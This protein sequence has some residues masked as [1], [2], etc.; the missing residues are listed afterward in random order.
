MELNEKGLELFELFSKSFTKTIIQS[1]QELLN[2]KHL[3]QSVRVEYPDKEKLSETLINEIEKIGEVPF[4]DAVDLFDELYSIATNAAW[5]IETHFGP[6]GDLVTSGVIDYTPKLLISPNTVKSYCRICENVEP[7]NFLHGYDVLNEFI[8]DDFQAQVFPLTYQCQGCKDVP[9][10]FLVRREGNKLTL[11]G[12]SPI[13]KVIVPKFLPKEQAMYVSNAI[14]A[15]NSG[16]ILSGIF[17]LRT[18]IEQYVRCSNPKTKDIESLFKEY[19][20]PLPND[21][22]DRFP[23]LKAIYDSLS[24]AIHLADPNDDIYNKARDDIYKH[25]DAKRIFEIKN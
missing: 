19:S 3:Y 13:E 5:K 22:N 9:E 20:S 8:E 7:F 14:V 12:R 15:Y 2:T 17:Q 1:L 25:F 21:F 4:N 10:V 23:S 11:S 24:V 18:F 6:R 16:Q